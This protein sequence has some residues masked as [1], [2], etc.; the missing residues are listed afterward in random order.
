MDTVTLLY[1]LMGIQQ[2]WICFLAW[3]YFDLRKK[4]NER[5]DVYLQF[6]R[7]RN[8]RLEQRVNDYLKYLQ[9][10]IDELKK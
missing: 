2:A 7:S 8:W 10:Q 4:V 3:V 1:V 6:S 9:K 5:L